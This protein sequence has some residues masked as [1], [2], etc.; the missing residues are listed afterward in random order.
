[1]S[2]QFTPVRKGFTLVEMITV[3]VIITVLA[4]IIVGRLQNGRDGITFQRG[5]QGIESAANK[6]K[7]Q[8]LQTGQTY[9]LTFD[10]T[11][12]SLKVAAVEAPASTGAGSSSIA[13]KPIGTAASASKPSTTTKGG[14]GATADTALGAGWTVDQVQKKDGTTDTTLSIKFYP[15]GTAEEKSVQFLNGKAPVSLTVK[16]NGSID[17][18]RGQLTT[19]TAQEWEAGNLEQRQG[20]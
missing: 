7:S 17:V 5:I 9:E 2:M 13:S 11:S 19:A 1:M 16:Q 4:S 10:S 8:A 3:V 20:G 15:D 12:Q 18:K 6:A 14:T